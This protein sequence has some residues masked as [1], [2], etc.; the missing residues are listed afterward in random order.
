M[1]TGTLL[2]GVGSGVGTA[3]G[4]GVGAAS[5]SGAAPGLL[6]GCVAAVEAGALGTRGAP[7]E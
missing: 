3:T 7:G 2:S 1:I 6:D 5:V 4:F